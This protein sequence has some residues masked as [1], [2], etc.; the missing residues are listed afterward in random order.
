MRNTLLNLVCIRDLRL[1][2]RS[3]N[4]TFIPYIISN[5]SICDIIYKRNNYTNTIRI[6][7]IS[8]KL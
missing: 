2:E 7:E 5:P 8:K 4:L 3:S 1:I 6:T